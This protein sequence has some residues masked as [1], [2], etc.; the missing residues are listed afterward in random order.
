M[1]ASSFWSPTR[2]AKDGRLNGSNFWAVADPDV[3]VQHW[4]Q[5]D[6]LTPK[7]VTEIQ[8]QGA[9]NY[10]QWVK[11]LKVKYGYETTQR[12]TIQESGSDKVILN[13][14]KEGG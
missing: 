2:P 9:K 5:I 13:F 14:F 12:T 10:G 1:T 8:T 7:V 3:P 11:T 6:F 4:I